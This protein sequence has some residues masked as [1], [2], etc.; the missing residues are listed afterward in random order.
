[1]FRTL[2]II[3]LLIPTLASA[4]MVELGYKAHDHIDSERAL[5]IGVE[6]EYKTMDIATRYNY[7]EINGVTS[8]H[9]GVLT[10]NYN[11]RIS[12]KWSL[13]FDESAGFDKPAGVKLEN[14][15]G[16][17]PKYIIV[18]TD[19]A[20]VSASAG[21]LSHYQHIE[22]SKHTT[23]RWSLRVK[24]RYKGLQAI[25]YHQPAVN[26]HDDY[27]NKAELTA[28]ATLSGAWALRYGVMQEY[29]S[30]E[31]RRKALQMMNL[32]YKFGG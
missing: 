32:V 19:N 6:H 13:W 7:G 29:R 25:G 2:V 15:I 5:H 10:L 3:I 11:H 28:E 26:N 20:K 18:K 9:D 12:R 16:A 17:G 23:D 14:R 31:G 27:I 30:A 8:T 1:M 22:D 4:G 21:Y 24:A